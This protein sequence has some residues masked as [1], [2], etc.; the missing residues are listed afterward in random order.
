M[1]LTLEGYAQQFAA[2]HPEAG[3]VSRRQLL[4]D[5]QARAL[6]EIIGNQVIELV[7]KPRLS[8]R[9]ETFLD[10]T[11]DLGSRNLIYLMERDAG[12][13]LTNA[14]GMELLEAVID[15]K[16]GAGMPSEMP[17]E[18]GRQTLINE[19]GTI[20]GGAVSLRQHTARRDDM[21]RTALNLTDAFGE[22]LSASG[23]EE[24]RLDEYLA[25]NLQNLLAHYEMVEAERKRQ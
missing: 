9:E 14:T 2:H 15:L 4:S 23:R 1:A 13:G 16:S 17:D 20:T 7:R 3:E 19:L 12:L 6:G 8:Q 25:G 10:V 11:V 24:I 22:L 21:E 5:R 18:A